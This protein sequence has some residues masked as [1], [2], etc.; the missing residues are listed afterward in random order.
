M[1]RLVIFAALAC[2]LDQA[3]KW[4]VV[5]GMDLRRIYAIDVLP[6]I[7]NFRYGENYGINFGLFG[8]SINRWVFI[9]LAMVIIAGLLWWLRRAAQPP[10]AYASAGLLIGGALGNVLDRLLYGYV[11]DFLNMSC[12]WIRNP[13]SFNVADVFV[14][15]G[16]VGLVLFAQ[17]KKRT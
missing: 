10:I 7:L 6:P 8:D 3:S 4:L 13:F 15:A 17:E 14:F 11:L 1:R 5:F 9:A 12:C 2:A 16:A